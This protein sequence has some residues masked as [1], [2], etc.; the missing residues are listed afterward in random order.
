MVYALVAFNLMTQGNQRIIY[1]KAK[2]LSE[3]IVALLECW[4]LFWIL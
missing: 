1:I 3:T 4:F 2:P